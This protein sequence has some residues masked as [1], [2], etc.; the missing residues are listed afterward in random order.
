MAAWATVLGMMLKD[1]NH[2]S[3]KFDS[4]LHLTQLFG[5]IAFVG[6]FA[7]IIWNLWTVWTGQRRWPAKVWSVVLALAA[8]V[9]LWIAFTFNLINFGTNY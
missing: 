1:Y 9:V 3:S 2:L 4:T 8:L 7:L 6:G 5:V